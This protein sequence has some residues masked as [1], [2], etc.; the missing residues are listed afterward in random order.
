MRARAAVQSKAAYGGG[1]CAVTVDPA[2]A[3]CASAERAEITDRR[4]RGAGG[5]QAAVLAS[6][7]RRPTR[8]V[9]PTDPI[10]RANTGA[11][12]NRLANAGDGVCARGA[13]VQA[14]F[15][16]R[17]MPEDQ[18]QPARYAPFALRSVESTWT[19]EAGHCC[20][21]TKFIS[22]G[23]AKLYRFEVLIYD[24]SSY[25]SKQG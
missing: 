3:Q 20:F 21:Q 25:H 8:A 14:S 12:S 13:T 19:H 10:R 6:C 2:P 17:L 1:W 15:A 23:D 11:A 24:A 22:D 9:L 18:R 4:A 5:T 16:L 7:A